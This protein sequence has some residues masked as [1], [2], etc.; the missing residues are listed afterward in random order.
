MG[1]RMMYN[2]PEFIMCERLPIG[3]SNVVRVRAL[4]LEPQWRAPYLESADQPLSQ[5]NQLCSHNVET[6][7]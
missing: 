1:T 2:M 5:S 3:W 6:L 4:C 7:A